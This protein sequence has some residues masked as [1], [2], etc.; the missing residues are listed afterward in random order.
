MREHSLVGG[1]D[2]KKKALREQ[3]LW[4]D[5]GE[6][7]EYVLV[8]RLMHRLSARNTTNGG[9]ETAECRAHF[10]FSP[11]LRSNQLVERCGA[12]GEPTRH[13]ARC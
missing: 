13:V 4:L 8:V 11:F 7:K 12:P 6:E 9:V 3:R 1:M 5:E 2:L 10:F